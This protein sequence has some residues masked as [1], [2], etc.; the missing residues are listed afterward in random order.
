[1]GLYGRHSVLGSNARFLA[2]RYDMNSDVVN[3]A[4]EQLQYDKHDLIQTAAHIREL[5]Y[6]RDKNDCTILDT[7]EIRVIIDALCTE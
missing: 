7:N 2:Y 4:W 6:M 1:M 5:F 3:M